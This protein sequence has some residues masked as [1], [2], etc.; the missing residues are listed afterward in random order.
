MPRVLVIE[1]DAEAGHRPFVA[2]TGAGGSKLVFQVCPDIVLPDLMLPDV[3]GATVAQS[4]RHDPQTQGVPIIMLTAKAEEVDRVVGFGLG[5]DDYVVKPFSVRELLLRIDAVLRRGKTSEQ[6]LIKVAE[7][8]ID[9]A[10]HRF[11]CASST[12]RPFTSC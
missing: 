1:D 9:T 5:A 2:A 10:A 3:S 8:C 11:S 6:E 7:V 4:L 12:G